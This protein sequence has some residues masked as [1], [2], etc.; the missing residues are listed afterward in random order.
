MLITA[1]AALLH[2]GIV[3]G[4]II[5]GNTALALGDRITATEEGGDI[6]EPVAE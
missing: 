6:V 4:L 2:S 5:D 3:N 1:A